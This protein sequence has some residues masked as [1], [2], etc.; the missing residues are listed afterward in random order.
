MPGPNAVAIN[1]S[2][3][4]YQ[5]LEQIARRQTNPYRLVQRA[6]LVLFAASGMNNTEIGEQLQLSRKQ[7]RQWRQRWLES[8]EQRQIAS[9]EGIKEPELMQ[10]LVMVLSDEQRP[11]GPAKFS[12]EQIVQIVAVACE[13]PASSGRPIS[14]WTPREL[15]LEV[16]KRGIVQEISPRS[17][18]RFLKRGNAATTS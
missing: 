2:D 14:H 12:L 18:G 10:Q 15:A 4:Q 5:L 6:K 8:V 17:V 11:G 1:V 9:A 3:R 7:V 16:V 13:Q